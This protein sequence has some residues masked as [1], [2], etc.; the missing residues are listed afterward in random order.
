VSKL[1]FTKG[2]VYKMSQSNDMPTLNKFLAD[3]KNSV[4]KHSDLNTILILDD[5][6][7]KEYDR[8]WEDGFTE[9]Y[10]YE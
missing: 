4:L 10:K 3:V 6:L 2:V 9:V 5:Y 1:G 8:G 7:Q